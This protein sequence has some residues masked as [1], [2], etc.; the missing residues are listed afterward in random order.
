MKETLSKPEYLRPAALWLSTANFL[1]TRRTL[2]V[3]FRLLRNLKAFSGQYI[4]GYFQVGVFEMNVK[5]S[6]KK[7][8]N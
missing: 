4:M 3:V 8:L 1:L 2:V 7:R 6:L 5:N